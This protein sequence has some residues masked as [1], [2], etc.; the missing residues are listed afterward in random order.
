MSKKLILLKAVL[1]AWEISA[2]REKEAGLYQPEDSTQIVATE[3]YHLWKGQEIMI[4]RMQE[5]L[6]SLGDE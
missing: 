4:K 5:L 2:K 6:K 3:H 1:D